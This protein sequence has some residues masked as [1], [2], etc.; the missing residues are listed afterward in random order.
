MYNR[1]AEAQRQIQ[2][3]QGKEAATNGEQGLLKS[4][5]GLGGVTL[6]GEALVRIEEE[7]ARR[8]REY[9]KRSEVDLQRAEQHFEK[10]AAQIES[11]FP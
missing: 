5:Q 3:A 9:E 11:K 8:L 1:L 7:Y 10:T 2:S 6:S 4:Q